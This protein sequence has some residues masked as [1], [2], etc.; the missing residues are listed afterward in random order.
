MLDYVNKGMH[1]VIKANLVSARKPDEAVTTHPTL[2][3]ALCD[4]LTERGAFVTVG[5]SPGGLYNSHH[6]TKVYNS[7]GMT[8]LVS[9]GV[10]LNDDFSVVETD[11]PEGKVLFV[12]SLR[13]DPNAQ[14]PVPGTSDRTDT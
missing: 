5:D 12:F 10:R 8:E 14:Y 6:L 3:G 7:T 4:L 2:I 11:F 9:R 1:I 13:S